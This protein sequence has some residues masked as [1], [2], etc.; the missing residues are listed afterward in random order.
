MVLVHICRYWWLGTFQCVLL[1][2]DSWEFEISITSTQSPVL[3]FMP[4]E[5]MCL[6]AHVMHCPTLQMGGCNRS[7]FSVRRRGE[8]THLVK[9]SQKHC[10]GAG[11]ET[12]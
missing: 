6:C 4:Y 7:H 2:W 5:P 12:H 9:K 8:E 11:L 3:F 1:G 10:C